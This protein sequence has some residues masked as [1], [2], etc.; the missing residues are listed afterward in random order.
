MSTC[1]HCGHQGD[2]NYCQD[3]G[4]PYGVKRITV[5]GLLHDVTHTFTHLEKGFGYTLK[6]LAIHP[7]KMQRRYLAGDR[8]KHQKP[9]SMFFI[10]ATI[11][12]LSFYWI[13]RNSTL[14][15]LDTTRN[16]FFRN[17]FVFLQVLLLPFYALVIW[18]LFWNRKFFYSEILI[19]QVYTTSFLLLLLIPI[20]L[21]NMIASPHFPASYIEITVLTIYAIW[22]N[23]N[24]FNTHPKWLVIVKSAIALVIGWF[25]ST[26]IADVV[27]HWM[28]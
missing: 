4:Q 11:T 25:A 20:N 2:G 14:T 19:L 26:S 5:T 18:I 1:L 10:C 9:F 17:Y 28:M 7:G 21:I 13:I 27:V 16:Y 23:M 6:E 3:C 22:T 8:V 15:D 12:G 24:F